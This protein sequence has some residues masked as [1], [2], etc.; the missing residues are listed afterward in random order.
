VIWLQKSNIETRHVK[1]LWNRLYRRP[2]ARLLR[3]QLVLLGRGSLMGVAAQAS[4]ALRAMHACSP[5]ALVRQGILKLAFE[6][7]RIS[8]SRGEPVSVTAS[9]A[10]TD[11]TAPNETEKRPEVL[12]VAPWERNRPV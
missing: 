7:G 1:T 2:M 9:G 4:R 3:E 12:P 10:K 5:S 6:S 8:T 11:L